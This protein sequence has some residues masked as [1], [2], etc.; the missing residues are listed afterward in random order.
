[1][2]TPVVNAPD[3][4]IA[5]RIYRKLDEVFDEDKRRFATG[6]TDEKIAKEIGTSPEL[7]TRIRREA[8]GELAEDPAIVT[9]RDD[10]IMATMEFSRRSARSAPTPTP[11]PTS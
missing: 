9:L 7:V 11:S 4:K 1:M 3:P 5:K 10:I 2:T 6:W 8:Y